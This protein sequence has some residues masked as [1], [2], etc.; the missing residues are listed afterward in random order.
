[1]L[2]RNLCCIWALHQGCL[3]PLRTGTWDL[4]QFGYVY[5]ITAGPYGT[6]LALC[7]SHRDDPGR[8]RVN[9]VLLASEP[10]GQAVLCWHAVLPSDACCRRAS[11][12]SASSTKAQMASDRRAAFEQRFR[13]QAQALYTCLE[14]SEEHWLVL[15]FALPVALPA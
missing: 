3:P 4:K 13:F 9:V 14:S 7:W 11:M 10:T 6:V 1:M 5:A 8:E 12:A 2:P 15:L